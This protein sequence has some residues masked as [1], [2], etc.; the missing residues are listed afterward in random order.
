MADNE[1][2]NE[3]PLVEPPVM[4]KLSEEELD[5]VD[6]GKNTLGGFWQDFYDVK[7]WS[8]RADV[9]FLF[10]IGDKLTVRYNFFNEDAVVY[11][12]EAVWSDEHKGFIDRYWVEE[13]DGD[14][15][16]VIRSNIV[17]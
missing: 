13:E 5:K 17:K 11:Y 14:H 7:S 9:E 2:K 8:N 3:R 12:Y 4:K 6:G 16:I 1:L 15:W 10:R